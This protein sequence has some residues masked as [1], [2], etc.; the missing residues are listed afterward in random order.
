M[1]KDPPKY[2][3]H[4]NMSKNTV[5]VM[6]RSR[7]GNERTSVMNA[8]LDDESSRPLQISHNHPLTSGSA[9]CGLGLI[10]TGVCVCLKAH[11]LDKGSSHT[12]ETA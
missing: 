10:R 11:N 3:G 4:Y 8:W 2:I 6:T 7:R 9:Y 1:L 12:A 5:F